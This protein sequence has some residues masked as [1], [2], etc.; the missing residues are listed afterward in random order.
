MRLRIVL[1]LGFALVGVALL[2]A[3]FTAHADLSTLSDRGLSVP[4]TVTRLET[5]HQTV[6]YS[7]VLPSG[8]Y[9]GVWDDGGGAGNPAYTDL[10]VGDIITAVYLPSA[11][12]KSV[13][14]DPHIRLVQ[15]EAV[16]GVTIGGF[17]LVGLTIIYAYFFVG[18]R[19]SMS[20]WRG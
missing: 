14:G 19:R 6:T 11:P 18:G 5:K 7:Y 3:D 8:T 17:F 1:I 20:V 15:Q 9:T 2:W 13:P 4:A 12:S 10:H 16:I